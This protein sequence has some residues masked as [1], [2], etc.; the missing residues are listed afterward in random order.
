M[1][2]PQSPSTIALL[3]AT[4]ILAATAGYM[5]GTASYLGLFN[6]SN[7][8]DSLHKQKKPKRSW[9][10]SYDVQIHPDS[11][12]EELMESLKEDDVEEEA[13]ESSSADDIG[14]LGSWEGNLEEC[15]MMFVVRTDL[16]M[17]KGRPLLL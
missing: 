7:S 14:Q 13:E 9:P 8:S 4:A 16:G 11:S 6:S 2:D 10:N 5:F 12:D 1:A 17:T 3:T 15:K